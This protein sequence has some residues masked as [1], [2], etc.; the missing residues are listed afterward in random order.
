MFKIIFKPFILLFELIYKIIDKII[1][2][3][4]SRLIYKLNEISRENSGKIEK[5]LNRPNV[6]IYVSL[7]CAVGIFLLVDAQVITLTET[8]AEIISGQKVQVTYNEEAYVVEGIPETVDITLIGSKSTIYLA[9]QLGEHQVSLDLSNY[10]TGTYKVKLKYN[11]S[12]QAVDYKLDPS[13]VTVKISEKVSK[14]KTLTYDLMNEDKLDSK[15]SISNVK[16]DT[17]EIIVKS[18]QEVLD[19]V[20][21][22]KALVDASQVNSKESGDFELENV[23]LVAYDEFGNKIE[24]IEMVP[25]KV[26]AIVTV[27]SYHAKKSVRVVTTGSMSNGKAIGSISS[28][29]SEVEIYGE[30]SVVDNIDEITAEVAVDSID[31]D[32]TLSVNLIKPAGVRYMSETTTNVTL[33]IA[34]AAQRTVSGVTVNTRGLGSEYSAGTAT[35]EDKMIDVIAKGVVSVINDNDIVSAEKINA[36]VDL[37]GLKPGTHT[38]KVNVEIDDERVSVQSTKTEITVRIINK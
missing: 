29:V 8:D 4:I 10:G 24:G 12:V 19:K 1:V 15:L 9:T 36:Y 6:L 13:V 35:T 3:P 33:T 27:D 31:G 34:D 18:S 30:K 20:A 2:T 22:V 28:S 38:V 14:V 37:T 23:A 17:N 26:N 25:S 11:H 16:L 32:K 7:L 5:I 21:V